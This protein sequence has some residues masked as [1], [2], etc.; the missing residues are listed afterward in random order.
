MPSLG[1][2]LLLALIFVTIGFIGGALVSLL[3][4]ERDQG[5]VPFTRISRK[6]NCLG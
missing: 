4:V 6:N 2:L 5:E 3:W 1:S